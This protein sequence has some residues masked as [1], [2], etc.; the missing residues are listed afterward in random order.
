[1]DFKPTK[2]HYAVAQP[3]IR[4]LGNT[5]SSLESVLVWAGKASRGG[6]DS[7]VGYDY[8]Q[9]LWKQ[10]GYAMDPMD[11]QCT[12]LS[13]DS[14]TEVVHASTVRSGKVAAPTS[15]AFNSSAWSKVSGKLPKG[16]GTEVVMYQK[17]G[18]GIGTQANNPWLQELP[19]PLTK[20]TWDNYITM[21]PVEMDGMAITF[22]QEN[23]L[24]LATLTV[25]VK[26]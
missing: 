19:D 8:I 11:N 4:P 2:S 7:K 14:G 15:P 26:Q 21:N 17:A 3:A 9:D 13:R 6:K 10:W 23:G 22:D 18:I 5:A 1:M 12:R 20:I 24:D 25:K 16:G